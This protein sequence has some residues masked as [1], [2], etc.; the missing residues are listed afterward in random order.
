MPC[1]S[2]GNLPEPGIKSMSLALQ[3]DSLPLS[4]Q[5]SR[6]FRYYALKG[7]GLRKDSVTL[8]LPLLSSECSGKRRRQTDV[9]QKCSNGMR[10]RPLARRGVTQW[11]TKPDF[12]TK[13]IG[14]VNACSLSEKER[15]PMRKTAFLPI[16][17]SALL[18][19]FMSRPPL[20]DSQ[21]ISKV[22]PPPSFF[23]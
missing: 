13:H 6:C 11:C 19:H 17:V 10:L 5:G 20:A 15:E 4:C 18:S 1:P 12:L 9:P 8:F 14:G 21:E 23:A 16:S 2:P 22:F 3:V 7:C